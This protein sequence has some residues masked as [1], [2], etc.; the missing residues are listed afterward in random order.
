M[1]INDKLV[2]SSVTSEDEQSLLDKKTTVFGHF[3]RVRH[4]K[5][6]DTEV[7]VQRRG[8]L[9]RSKSHLYSFLLLLCCFGVE[10]VQAFGV[11][12]RNGYGLG[13]HSF[14]FALRFH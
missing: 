9:K 7:I 2:S 1:G 10:T 6:A 8:T 11:L 13:L 14:D 12:G 5:C 3:A 4:E